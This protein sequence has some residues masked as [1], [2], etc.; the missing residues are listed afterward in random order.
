[1]NRKRHD[2]QSMTVWGILVTLLT[3]LKQQIGWDLSDGQVE[4][5]AT[6]G[7]QL[8]GIAVA[9]F[10]RKRI[11]DLRLLPESKAPLVAA[12]AV[13]AAV[14][15]GC[16]N[17]PSNTSSSGSAESTTTGA[18]TAYM[19]NNGKQ[20]ATMAG[21]PPTQMKQDSKGTWITTP[22]EGGVVT[23]DPSSGKMYAWSP[24]NMQAD[25][26]SFTPQPKDGEPKILVE[27]FSAN[28][29]E[30]SEVRADQFAS[31]VEAMKDMSE[32]EARRYIKSMVEARKIS[33]EAA[34]VL[35]E[36]LPMLIGG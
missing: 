32:D 1:M 30:V 15:A 10:G 21:V 3:T 27:G 24:K 7:L 22:G 23:L 18:S 11:G 9:Y 31:A 28:M 5:Y 13:L 36:L 17:P 34:G 20:T 35:E 2:L 26:I 8:A 33:E 6:I 25:R 19:D 4:Q 14:F 16:A 12:T 29:S